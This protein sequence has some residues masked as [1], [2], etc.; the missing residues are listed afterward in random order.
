MTARVITSCEKLSCAGTYEPAPSE[1][2]SPQIG[3]PK[4]GMSPLVLVVAGA[5]VGSAATLLI[6]TVTK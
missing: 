3:E 6:K 1:A 5:V 2:G 4:K